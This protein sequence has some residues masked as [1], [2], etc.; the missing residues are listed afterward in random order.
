MNDEELIARA[1]EVGAAL[2]RRPGDLDRLAGG[3]LAELAGRLAA[4]PAP[5]PRDGPVPD[6]EEPA[7]IIPAC[8]RCKTEAPHIAWTGADEDYDGPR[9]GWQC[10]R[11]GHEWS[12]PRED[13]AA[14]V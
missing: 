13:G 12:T 11:C 6:E 10:A 2:L 9:D 1:C 8:P 3:L 7:A 14:P 5:A 4:R